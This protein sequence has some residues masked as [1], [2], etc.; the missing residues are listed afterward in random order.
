MDKLI[1]HT[2][3]EIMKGGE[4]KAPVKSI[5]LKVKF[6]TKKKDPKREALK[7]YKDPLMPKYH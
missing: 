5:K 4:K 2:V 1:G 3:K 7:R 6:D